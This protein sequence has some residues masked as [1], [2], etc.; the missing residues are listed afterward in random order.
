[1]YKRIRLILRKKMP[2]DRKT[3]I[4][5]ITQ[6][7]NSTPWAKQ[8]NQN[9]VT[10]TSKLQSDCNCPDF[11]DGLDGKA[12]VYNAGDLGSIRG[13]GRSPGGGNGN[14]LQY[15]C[16]ENP[17]DRGAWQATV[18]GVTKSRTRLSDFTFPLLL[19]RLAS[20]YPYQ[21]STLN[22]LLYKI[23]KQTGINFTLKCKR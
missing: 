10:R 7:K 21:T 22:L 2:S 8:G 3:L 13:S 5:S 14:S 4:S 19:E 11:P 9:R 16:L 1:M 20:F 6:K 18:H 12:S 23:F 17:M 15:S